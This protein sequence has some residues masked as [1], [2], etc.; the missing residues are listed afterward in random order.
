MRDPN[1]MLTLLGEMSEQDSGRLVVVNP[2]DGWA[3]EP[4]RRHHHMELLVDAGHAEWLG[5]QQTVA[6][7]TNAG[8]GFLNATM[9]P[10]SGGKARAEF[11]KLLNDGVSYVRAAQTAVELVAKTMGA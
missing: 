6:R 1:L 5:D 11:T 8:Y 3:G 9:S 10:S 2:G 4:H 7:I